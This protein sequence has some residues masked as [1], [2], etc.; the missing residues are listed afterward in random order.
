[1]NMQSSPFCLPIYTR[2]DK[3]RHGISTYRA[4]CK[5]N[6]LKPRSKFSTSFSPYTHIRLED[7]TIVSLKDIKLNDVI[8]GGIVVN[9][10]L[11]I[12]NVDMVPFYKI[13]S[14]ELNEYI[15]VTGCHFIRESG[16]FIRV[17]DSPSAQLTDIIED[18]FICLITSTHHIPIGEHTFWDWSDFCES[19]NDG[20][21]P[22]EFFVRDRFNKF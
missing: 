10:I 2:N 1:M 17:R 7:D 3:H 9:T 22:Q 14:E 8:K 6:N 15:Y 11:K 16:K 21:I 19:C 5:N 18:M 13:L 4:P 12:R 20:N